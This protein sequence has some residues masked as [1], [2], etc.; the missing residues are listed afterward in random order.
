[1]QEREAEELESE[2]E[3]GRAL[4]EMVCGL[5]SES[6]LLQARRVERLLVR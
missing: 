2:Q 3:I 1:M 6:K 5:A 4:C